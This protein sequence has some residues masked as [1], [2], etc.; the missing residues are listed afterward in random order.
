MSG[1]CPASSPFAAVDFVQPAESQS[2][3]NAA[4]SD[5]GHSHSAIHSFGFDPSVVEQALL[6]TEGD[7]QQAVN[8]ILEGLVPAALEL[9][10]TVFASGTSPVWDE[11]SFGQQDCSFHPSA[12]LSLGSSGGSSAD[13]HSD[14]PP[15]LLQSIETSDPGTK[16][17]KGYGENYLEELN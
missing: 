12:T 2:T 1:D 11:L 16:D 10:Q 15:H 13:H 5:C 4:N 8:L 3:E 9:Q 6:L 17:L 7:E 14:V